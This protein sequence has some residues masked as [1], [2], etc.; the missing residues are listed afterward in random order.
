V[1]GDMALMMVSQDLTVADVENPAKDI[2]FPDSVVSMLRGDLGQSPGGWPSSL[3]K[4]ALKGE[5]P[6]TVRPGSLLKAAD[7]EASRK[8]IEE[9]LGRQLSEY[10]FAS[11]L[12]YPKV[13]ADFAGAQDSYGPVS[14]LPTPTYFYGMKTEDEIFVDIEKGKTL[15]VRCLA[16]GDTDDKGMVTVFFEINGQP[17]RVKVPN[18]SAG[19]AAGAIRR[20][21]EAGDE[22]HVG[23]PMPGVVST[24]AVSAG[25]SV[26]AGDVL[27]SIEA[28]KMETALHAERDGTVTEVLVRAGDQIDAKDLLVVLS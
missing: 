19:A 20:K 15:V 17:R 1:V 4:K 8:E 16:F 25:Q 12:M 22:S 5:T 21:A 28:M 23:A 2:A 3:Q 9:K 26:K 24:L 18:R 7:L 27:L 6:I 10:E 11:W 14:V 13:F